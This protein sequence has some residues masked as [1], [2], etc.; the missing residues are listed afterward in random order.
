MVTLDTIFDLLSKER[1]RYTLYYLEEQNGKVPVNELA[2]QVAEWEDS[3]D[4]LSWEKYERVRVSME[5]NDL[6]KTADA[7][8]I[9]YNPDEGVVEISGMSL[10]ADAVISLAKVIEEPESDE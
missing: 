3:G 2:K 10:E 7:E 9:E 6:P 8:F 4:E 1:R 5:H